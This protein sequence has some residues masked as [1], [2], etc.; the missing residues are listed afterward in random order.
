MWH[1]LHS[2]QPTST[3]VLAG[4]REPGPGRSPRNACRP[5]AVSGKI[6]RRLKTASGHRDAYFDTDFSHVA[7][8]GREGRA[9]EW[10]LLGQPPREGRAQQPR[11]WSGC[12]RLWEDP[13]AGPSDAGSPRLAGIPSPRRRA[14][15]I[16]PPRRPWGS[17]PPQLCARCVRPTR[18]IPV[19]RGRETGLLSPRPSIARPNRR[20]GCAVAPGHKRRRTRTRYEPMRQRGPSPPAP[21]GAASERSR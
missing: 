7:R 8:D 15:R 17:P 4:V 13:S 18:D 9:P 11:P 16:E 2:C 10:S 5:E 3:L 20:V 12:R 14:G 19:R 21:A 1:V 6:N